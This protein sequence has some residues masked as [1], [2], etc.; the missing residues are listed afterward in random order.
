MGN[1]KVT[2]TNSTSIGVEIFDVFNNTNDAKGT[3]TYTSLGKIG[4]GESKD[5]QTIHAASQLQAMYTGQVAALNNNYYYQFPVAVI[6][7]SILSDATSYS[8]TDDQKSAMENTFKFIKYTTANADSKL[9]K[10]FITALSSSN[11]K[12]AVNDFF[13]GSASFKQC[14]LV[15]WTAVVSWQ[16]QFLSAWQGPYYLYNKS[17]D[18]KDIKLVGVVNIVSNETENS[19]KL[20]MADSDG[21][22]S[23]SAESTDL[24]M[25]GNGSISEANAGTGNVSV[26]LNAV[27]LNVVNTKDKSNNYVIG[28]SLSGT[29]NGMQVLGTQQKMNF[30][31][32]SGSGSGQQ[33]K[34]SNSGDKLFNSIISIVGMLTGIGSMYIM[35]KQWKESGKQKSNEVVNKSQD[36]KGDKENIEKQQQAVE[37]QSNKSMME[38]MGPRVTLEINVIVVELPKAEAEAAAASK[39]E[40][41]EEE[42]MEEE[43]EL[44]DEMEE[45]APDQQVEDIAEELKDA[46]A[47]VEDG[48]LDG[49][50]DELDSAKSGLDNEEADA[51][52][53]F[54]EEEKAAIENEKAAVE[55]NEEQA[56]DVEEAQ[57]DHEQESEQDDDHSVDDDDFNEPE[58]DEFHPE[59]GVHGIEK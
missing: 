45:V 27:W 53:Q 31:G 13:A 6:A 11:Q 35:Y 3:L 2:I 38:D 37:E 16:T 50:Q 4:A 10:D 41:V 58:E 39:Q 1:P 20:T 15:N 44:E 24:A 14:T 30:S 57:E 17:T 59:E 51:S 48:N 19:A 9:A 26:S 25:A 43:K 12:K 56:K 32:S 21:N 34:A 47:K 7:V 5:I 55:E 49:V 23:A 8:V 18:G 40:H 46:E 29:I 54:S 36:P 22:V 42:V 28:S 52:A 33:G